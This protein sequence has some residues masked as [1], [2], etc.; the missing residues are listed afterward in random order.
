MVSETAG[1]AMITVSR[2]GGSTGA[3]SVG[4][5]TVAG[6]SATPGSDYLGSAST[7]SWGDGD[8]ADKTFGVTL[9]DDMAVDGAKTVNLQL[10]NPLAARPW[11][12]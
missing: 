3:V 10:S 1:N 8:V 5:A 2:V 9:L 7:L 12:T 11:A 6:G 4:F